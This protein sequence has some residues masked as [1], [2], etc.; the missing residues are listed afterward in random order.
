SEP[1]DCGG[2]ESELPGMRRV[3]W[4]YRALSRARPTPLEGG[5]PHPP[6]QET[7]V[8]SLPPPL[9]GPAPPAA[10]LPGRLVARQRCPPWPVTCAPTAPGRRPPRVGRSRGPPSTAWGIG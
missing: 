7:P 1:Q 10:A 5:S 6:I 4:L 8:G 3:K 2:L 9:R